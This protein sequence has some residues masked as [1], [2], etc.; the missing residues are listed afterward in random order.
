MKAYG[1]YELMKMQ[2]V[3]DKK[4]GRNWETGRYTKDES[5]VLSELHKN[6]VEDNDV[7]LLEFMKRIEVIEA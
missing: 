3:Y 7:I 5:F 1:R 4:T 6:K 2:L